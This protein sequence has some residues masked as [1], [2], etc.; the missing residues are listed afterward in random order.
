MTV[1]DQ[2]KTKRVKSNNQIKVVCRGLF[3][4]GRKDK[5]T[6]QEKRGTKY[7]K[8]IIIEEHVSLVEPNSNIL[9]HV[10]PKSGTGKDIAGSIIE[11][12]GDKEHNNQP[13]CN[14]I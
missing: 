10:T 7:Y 11:Y 8:R 2:M 14:G 4:G 12:L 9:G 13:Y 5:I 1:F 6:V 3:F